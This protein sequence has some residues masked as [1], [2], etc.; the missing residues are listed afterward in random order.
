M[1]D[2]E[3]S[4]IGPE[5]IAGLRSDTRDL[6]ASV[7]KLADR[8]AATETRVDENEA[9]I[10]T[11]KRLSR[12]ANFNS[13]VAVLAAVAVVIMIVLFVRW[14]NDKDADDAKASLA[15][16]VAD[17][18][19]IGAIAEANIAGANRIVVNPVAQEAYAQGMREAFNAVKATKGYSADCTQI[20][21]PP[22]TTTTQ[23]GG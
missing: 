23:P 20:G 1:D 18:Q 9:Q 21:P 11:N 14:V 22:T 6:T 15:R 10:R 4:R 5:D 8:Q 19:S 7:E 2:D 13:I 17:C 12:R 3:P 16:R